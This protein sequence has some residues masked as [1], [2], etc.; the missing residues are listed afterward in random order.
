MISNMVIHFRKIIFENFVQKKKKGI[1][2]INS[3]YALFK[4][5]IYLFIFFIFN[6]KDLIMVYKNMIADKII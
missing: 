4:G 1:E 5:F 3:F 2:I 6:L